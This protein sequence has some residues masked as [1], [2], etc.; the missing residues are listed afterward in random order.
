MVKE[1]NTWD[2]GRLIGT[3]RDE[4]NPALEI[5]V[6]VKKGAVIMEFCFKNKNTIM[7]SRKAA[8]HILDY[9]GKSL[10]LI[11]AQRI[12]SG[13][14]IPEPNRKGCPYMRFINWLGFKKK[15]GNNES[16]R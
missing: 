13:N 16:T 7:L 4:T 10:E 5:N 6:Y 2:K 3:V 8:G 9:L 1:T 11:K 12:L 14:E 15:E